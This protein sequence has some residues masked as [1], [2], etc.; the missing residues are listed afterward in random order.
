MTDSYS[1]A[2]FRFNHKLKCEIVR[3]SSYVGETV[4]RNRPYY[5]SLQIEG[6]TRKSCITQIYFHIDLCVWCSNLFCYFF[7][8]SG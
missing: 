1:N 8:D 7:Y 5:E 2:L 3:I 6:Q 4:R